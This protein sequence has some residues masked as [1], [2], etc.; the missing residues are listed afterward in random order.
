MTKSTINL[1]DWC[2]VPEG[3]VTIGATV[4]YT[5]PHDLPARFAR[6]KVTGP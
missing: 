2:P 1:V 5:I 6:L 4:D 3:Q